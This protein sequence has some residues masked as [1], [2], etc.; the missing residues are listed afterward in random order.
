MD[1][2]KWKKGNERMKMK[3]DVGGKLRNLGNLGTGYGGDT[4]R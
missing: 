4:S 1:K 3:K 2:V